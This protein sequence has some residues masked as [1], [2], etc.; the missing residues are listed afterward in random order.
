MAST[1]ILLRW[2]AISGG[3]Q[4]YG[5]YLSAAAKQSQIKILPTSVSSI[6]QF[7]SSAPPKY[8][9]A[10]VNELLSKLRTLEGDNET[11]RK[12]KELLL[13]SKEDAVGSVKQK[14]PLLKEIESE[15]SKNKFSG[16][17]VS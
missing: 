3:S 8:N 11:L 17:K 7:A 9:E 4:V 6:R 13:Q 12:Q 5:R 1:T 14:H 16:K 2:S 15:I 10:F